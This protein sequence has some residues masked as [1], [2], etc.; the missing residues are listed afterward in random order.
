M[1]TDSLRESGL[2]PCGL[3]LATVTRG[4]TMAA[5]LVL[6][7]LQLATAQSHNTPPKSIDWLAPI[8]QL[9]AD[10]IGLDFHQ[11]D[12]GSGRRYIVET[13]LGSVA[14]FDYDNDGWLDVYFPNGAPLPGT[15]ESSQYAG[16]RLFRNL[17]NWQFID[18]TAS[19][20]L[21]GNSYSM[22]VVVGDY[23][24]DGDADLFLSN[25]GTNNFY[26]NQ[27]DGTFHECAEACGL[28]GL[29]RFGAG[30]TFLDF[31]NDGDLDLYCA[32][33]VQ[34]D[35]SNHKPRTIAG[36]QFHPGPNDYPPAADWL[37]RN[38]G[39]GRF[40]M[41]QRYQASTR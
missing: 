35:F 9:P 19:A 8:V 10:S 39:D 21:K 17:G 30:N 4:K 7:P 41:Y 3:V 26:V 31:D 33:Y 12:G 38:E 14:V 6:W 16:H 2:A 22:G 24:N 40:T 23:D 28:K 13:V 25:Y 18:V 15:P 36:Y 29:P 34:F 32:S 27:G 1:L 20:G 5:L 11:T 37:Y